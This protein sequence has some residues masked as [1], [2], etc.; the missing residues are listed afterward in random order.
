[1]L[2]SGR[3]LKKWVI[4]QPSSCEFFA[5]RPQALF[6]ELTPQVVIVTSTF[7]EARDFNREKPGFLK[8][9][10]VFLKKVFWMGLQT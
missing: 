2:V 3:V 10:K 4:F 6:A 8:V 5:P 1:M 9:L 7:G